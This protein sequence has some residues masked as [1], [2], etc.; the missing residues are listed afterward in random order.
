MHMY[1]HV[2]QAVTVSAPVTSLF[3]L[4]KAHYALHLTTARVTPQGPD[5]EKHRDA[6]RL[7][8]FPQKW[9]YVSGSWFQTS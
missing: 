8:N 2:S 4:S 9:Q 6:L 7:C 5:N 1:G 3:G